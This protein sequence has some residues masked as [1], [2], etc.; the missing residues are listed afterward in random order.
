[1]SEEK[2]ISSRIAELVAQIRKG[3]A[4]SNCVF[5]GP[6]VVDVLSGDIKATIALQPRPPA[7]SPI[8]NAHTL[9]PAFKQ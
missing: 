5:A 2:P 3:A 1:M 9:S 6:I 7:P 8:V 4:D